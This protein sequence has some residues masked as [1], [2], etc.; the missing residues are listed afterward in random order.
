MTTAASSGLNLTLA[1]TGA[2]G[3]AVGRCALQMLL[4]DPRVQHLNLVVSRHARR[5]AH[6]ELAIAD[7][8]RSAVEFAAALAGCR[9]LPAKLQNL[10]PE[11]IGANIASGSYASDG[12]LVAPCSMGTLASIAH[13]LSNN[14]IE[15]AADVC[16]KER[17]RLVLAVRET[18]LS[19]IHLRNMLAV[20]EAGGI[21]FPLIPAFYD[22]A[23]TLEA[24]ARQFTARLLATLGL[25]Q[26][27]A[28]QWPG[29]TQ[30]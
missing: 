4:A 2:S 8:F 13:G 14:L 12:M 5:V 19:V 6:E 1:V 16:L 21:V 20:S 11:D 30:T 26:S 9:P 3:A 24:A 17:R 15:R 18:P 28:F 29:G 25:P 7:E 10:E 23:T 22:A 27:A